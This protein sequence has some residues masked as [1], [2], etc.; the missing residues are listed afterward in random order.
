MPGLLALLLCLP[1]PAF[2]PVHENDARRFLVAATAAEQNWRFGCAHVE[3]LQQVG[4]SDTAWHDEACWCRDVWDK[5]DDVKRFWA[6]RPE[7]MR[8]SL[9]RLRELLGP[10]WYEAGRLPPAA[11][12]WRFRER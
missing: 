8:Q 4:L 3:W 7:L 5:V 6:G 1:A 9:E 2:V 12:A 11:P 10:E